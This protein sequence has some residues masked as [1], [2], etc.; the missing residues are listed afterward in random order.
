MNEPKLSVVYAGKYYTYNPKKDI[1]TFELAKIH[2]FITVCL[3][4]PMKSEDRDAYIEK[5]ELIRHFDYER[6]LVKPEPP[7]T[8][9][10]KIKTLLK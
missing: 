9:W 3:W 10:Q 7:K 2:Q 5:Y 1:T 4:A 8:L 6:D